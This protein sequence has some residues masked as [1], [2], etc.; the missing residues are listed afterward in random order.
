MQNKLLLV[1]MTCGLLLSGYLTLSLPSFTQAA[2]GGKTPQTSTSVSCKG[3]PIGTF[4]A[5]GMIQPAGVPAYMYGPFRL[6]DASGKTLYALCSSNLD[7][8]QYVGKSVELVA[9][10]IPG[11]PIDGGPVYLAVTSVIVSDGTAS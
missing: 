11:Y 1:I 6:T 5:E 3:G 9:T 8:N 10:S 4:R 7:L 2:S